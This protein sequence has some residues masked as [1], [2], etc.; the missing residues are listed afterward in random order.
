[1]NFGVT[2]HQ[3]EPFLAEEANSGEVNVTSAQLDGGDG[4]PMGTEKCTPRRFFPRSGAGSMS[5]GFKMLATVVRA[6][7]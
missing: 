4:G 1:M 7:V 2:V 5:F 6:T 3:A